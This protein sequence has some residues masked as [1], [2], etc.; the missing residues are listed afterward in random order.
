MPAPA[1]PASRLPAVRAALVFATLS[2]SG[3]L[4]PALAA[5]TNTTSASPVSPALPGSAISGG[6]VTVQKGD[7][8]YSLAR[9]HGLKVD[10]LLALNGLNTPD[11]QVGQVLRVRAAA[12]SHT[13][14]PKETLYGISRQYGL[15]VDALLAANHL[16]PAAVLEIGQVL[17]IPGA[18]PVAAPRVLAQSLPV[19]PAPAAFPS[20]PA[21]PSATDDDWRGTAM[22]LLGVPYV[23]GG[24]SR[25]GLDCSGF[26]LQVFAPLGMDLPR[27]S[28]AQARVGQPVE[29]GDLQ[30]GDLVFFDT[31]GRGEVTHVGIYLGEN[32]FVNANSYRKQVAVDRLQGDP[33]WEPKLMGARRVLPPL[34]YGSARAR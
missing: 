2:L 29:V 16:P 33:Y 21:S 34:M 30:A 11:L 32:Q 28:A 27:T 17:Q 14:Q 5:T 4:A 26:V 15:S 9:A 8:A 6:V 25:S 24:T 13:V 3:G 22:A 31:V 19:L 10:E 18:A 1:L 23:Y 20:V 7:T 12:A